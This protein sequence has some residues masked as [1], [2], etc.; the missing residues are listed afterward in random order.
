MRKGILSFWLLFAVSIVLSAIIVS[1]FIKVLKLILFV[2]LVLALAPVVY[3]ILRL[4][5]PVKKTEN[6]KPDTRT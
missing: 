4:L 3:I 5:L 1:L 2:I 6:D